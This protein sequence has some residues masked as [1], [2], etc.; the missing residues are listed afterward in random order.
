MRE[1]ARNEQMVRSIDPRRMIPR[2][3]QWPFLVVDL[4]GTCAAETI[5]AN[6]HARAY[7]KAG[8]M[9]ASDP[10]EL[11]VQA[12]QEGA[13]HIWNSAASSESE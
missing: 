11:F 2:E 4:F 7:E 6:V 3:F 13:V 5:L 9:D 12:L 10:I 8:H 1:L